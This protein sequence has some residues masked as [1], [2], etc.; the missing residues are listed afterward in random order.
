M[1]RVLVKEIKD[2]K[3]NYLIN[4]NFDLWQRTAANQVFGASQNYH[5]DRFQW[6]AGTI[7]GQVTSEKAVVTDYSNSSSL[8]RSCSF[9]QRYTTTTA[10]PSLGADA[11]AG[12]WLKMEGYDLDEIL[13][14]GGLS[15]GITLSFYVASSV[16]G[17]YT[18]Q[19]ANGGLNNF[20][21]TTYTIAVAN[22]WQRV[23]IRLT[24]AEL[25][26]GIGS[27]TWNYTNG[28][29]MYVRFWLASGTT[30]N[31][32]AQNLWTGSTPNVP[33]AQV[34]L[35]STLG[36][37]WGITGLMMTVGNVTPDF[38]IRANSF[39]EELALAQQYYEKSYPLDTPPG[40]VAS[41]GFTANK[42]VSELARF[43]TPFLIRKRALP[44]IT[45]YAGNGT[46]NA[47]S[48]EF[49]DTITPNQ[50]T[51]GYATHFII[52]ITSGAG[53]PWTTRVTG[54][55]CSWHWTADAEL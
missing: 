17:T 19:F 10:Q 7:T 3:K 15:N 12:P 25:A 14:Q 55:P 4:G 30:S 43:S 16:T 31:G 2:T 29:G 41:G 53:S 50:A 36:R 24:A 38:K 21:F 33:A 5:A 1:P 45:V 44:A 34:N 6:A 54:T 42:G 39:A 48:T 26:I 52:N 18:V 46:I 32:V 28:I 8:P 49:G 22:T 13:E 20:Y 40:T 23:S 51:N 9:M 27:G 35:L 11:T 37:T 47:I